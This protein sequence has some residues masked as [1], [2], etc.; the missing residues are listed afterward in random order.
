MTSIP[1]I[2]QREG[3]RERNKI[4]SHD[5]GG[6]SVCWWPVSQCADDDCVTEKVLPMMRM[7]MMMIWGEENMQTH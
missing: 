2:N 6:F 1:F 4:L 3:D 5:S 7:T